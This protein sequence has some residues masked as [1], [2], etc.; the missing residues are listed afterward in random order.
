[1]TCEAFK[2]KYPIRLNRQ[3][4]EAVRQTEGPVLLKL[5]AMTLRRCWRKNKHIL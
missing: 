4:E 2:T 3:Q 1:M 5:S